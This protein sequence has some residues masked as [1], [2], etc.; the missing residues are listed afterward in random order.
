[1]ANAEFVDGGGRLEPAGETRFAATCAGGGEELEKAS[2]TEQIEIGCV[3]M[4]RIGEALAGFPAALPAMVETRETALVKGMARRT[5][6]ASRSMRDC[7]QTKAM[8]AATGRAISKAGT[9]P[10]MA[11]QMRAMAATAISN[12]M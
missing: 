5:H 6:S 3:R 7:H 2:A 12:R 4:V 11:N 8:K 1:M 9:A 10:R